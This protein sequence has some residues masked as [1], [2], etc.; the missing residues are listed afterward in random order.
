MRFMAS[1]VASRLMRRLAASAGVD[2]PS[3]RWRYAHDNPWFDNQVA[4]L[5]LD[6]RKAR[7]ML[8]KTVRHEEGESED[9][10]RLERVYEREL[11]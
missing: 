1:E 10:L 3:V 4:T 7:M 9:D 11:A 5:E 8:E 2:A 6:G